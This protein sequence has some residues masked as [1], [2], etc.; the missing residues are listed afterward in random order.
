LSAYVRM[1][2][3]GKNPWP[4]SPRGPLIAPSLLAC[5]FTRV[6]QEIDAVI[7]AGAEVLHADVMD[8]H[9]VPN[10]SM[11]PDFVEKI[12]RYTRWPID[13]HIMVTNP[14][15]YIDRFAEVGADSVSFHIETT[16]QPRRL[17]DTLH[18]MGL[19]AG[20]VLKPGTPAEAIEPVADAVDLVMVM[21]VEP[22]YGGQPFLESMLPKIKA[23]RHRVG[24]KVRVQVDGGLNPR[25]AAAS[26]RAGAD[27]LVAGHFI[28]N[29]LDEADAIAQL[30]GAAAQ[31]AKS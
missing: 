26:A 15:Y 28:F 22:G 8:G 1:E 12:R 6:G 9:F 29:S 20:V 27:V 4:A 25:T 11:G 5:D 18:R 7:A 31:V 21:T 16:D 19:G 30:R 14:A 10:L 23:V 17:A 3:Q 2:Y 13:V 24:P